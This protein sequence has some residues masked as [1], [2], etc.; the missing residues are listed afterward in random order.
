MP[1]TRTTTRAPIRA[2]SVVLSVVILMI[3][4]HFL[5]YFS[6]ASA[7][8]GGAERDH[9]SLASICKSAWRLNQTALA[10]DIYLSVSQITGGR[11]SP[12][13]VLVSLRGPGQPALPAPTRIS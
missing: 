7:P 2:N 6:V 10:N 5:Y 1:A 3:C 12:T 9:N 4:L 8:P 11:L 13:C